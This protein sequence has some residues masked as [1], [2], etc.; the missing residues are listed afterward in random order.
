M[1]KEERIGKTKFEVMIMRKN[2]RQTPFALRKYYGVMIIGF[3]LFLGIMAYY[4]VKFKEKR[5]L[6]KQEVELE[7]SVDVANSATQE[8][9]ETSETTQNT[10]ETS[11]Q[12]AAQT[13]KQ[14]VTYDGKT[15]L[16]W[17]I[18]GNV[19]LP[20]STE[21][22]VYFETLDQYRTNPGIL[23]EAQE[24]ASVK[25][26][27]QAKVTEIKNSAEYGQ[28]VC[29]DLGSGY[30][31]MYG[32]MKEL[33]VKAGDTVE[34]GQVIGKVAAPTSYYTLEGTNLYFQMEKDKK[35]IDPG[36]YLE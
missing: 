17:P 36:K 2:S 6:A 11:T 14:T 35:S 29:M 24:N 27:K 13:M 3:V 18:T 9:A 33:T 10:A 30:T 1:N 7:K 15:K 19:L 23:I 26:V 8:T 25:A 5:E 34:K 31:A 32:Q 22:T 21:A 4:S 16:S 28:T 20:Y 12:K